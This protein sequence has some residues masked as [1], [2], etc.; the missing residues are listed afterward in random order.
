MR[1]KFLLSG[2]LIILTIS[3]LFIFNNNNELDIT[4]SLDKVKS[5]TIYA[6]DTQTG[7]NY[8]KKRLSEV[9]FTTIDNP[10]TYF[11]KI[12]HKNEM[13]IWKGDKFGIISM[14]DGTEFKIRVSDY[15]KFFSVIGEDGFYEYEK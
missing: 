4:N 2:I 5:I 13:T 7:M 3:G 1:I 6:I 10:K 11:S 9:G 12:T 15:G 14:K 8:D